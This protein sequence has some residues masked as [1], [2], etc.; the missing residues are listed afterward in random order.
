LPAS[1]ATAKTLSDRDVFVEPH[2]GHLAGVLAVIV[3]CNCS[4]LA[5]HD[6]QV[7][8]YIGMAAVLSAKFV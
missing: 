5:L 2:W 4:K 1:A 8:S 7:Y 6:W 3:R